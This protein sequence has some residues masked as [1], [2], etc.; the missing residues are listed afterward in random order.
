MAYL[1]DLL[2]QAQRRDEADKLIE[3]ALAAY[4][5]DRGILSVAWQHYYKRVPNRQKLMETQERLIEL[6][7]VS[8]NRAA[9]LAHLYARTNRGP[10][11]IALL[12]RAMGEFPDQ[13]IDLKFELGMIYEHLGDHARSEAVMQE[14][15]RDRPDHDRAAN[16]LGY[17]WANR[18]ERLDEA[19]TLLE[20]AVAANRDQAAYLDS[21]GWV[22]YKLGRFPE[23]VQ[24]LRRARNAP[25][26]DYPVILDHLGDALYRTGGVKEAIASWTRAQ[27]RL[28]EVDA[29]EDS[30]ILGLGERLRAKLEAAQQGKAA[31][32]ADVPAAGTG[33]DPAPSPAAPGGGRPESSKNP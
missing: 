10:E 31:P 9:Q 17:A 14:V 16:A 30:E 27:Q 4:P 8:P 15:L 24:Q 26:G 12:N 32:V 25:G 13:A 1:D 5:R 3:D 33:S 21:L 2:V 19:R 18:G 28:A 20:R 22:Y 6:Q 11:A 29:D 7:P 23:A